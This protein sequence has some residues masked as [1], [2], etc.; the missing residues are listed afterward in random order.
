MLLVSFMILV[1]A[2]FLTSKLYRR[3]LSDFILFIDVAI[4]IFTSF[5]ALLI[6][7]NLYNGLYKKYSSFKTDYEH[8][9]YYIDSLE[10]QKSSAIK[11]DKLVKT[12]SDESLTKI[13]QIQ[14][15]NTLQSIANL[16]SKI[17]TEKQDFRYKIDSHNAYMKFNYFGIAA[18]E[19]AK[20]KYKLAYI[21]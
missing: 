12:V 5:I 18:I 19:D 2:S 10:S 6:V 7:L 13:Y 17:E 3:K 8:L 1:L 9:E 11:L 16:T 14:L 15:E 20:V 4:K 21:K